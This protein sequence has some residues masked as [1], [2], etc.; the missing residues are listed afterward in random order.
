M[1]GLFNSLRRRLLFVVAKRGIKR[2]EAPIWIGGISKFNGNTYLGKNTNFNGIK[3]VGQGDFVVGDN[4]H[5]GSGLI[6]ITSNHRFRNATRIPYDQEHILKTVKIED[7]VWIGERVTIL[8][9]VHIGEGAIIQAGSV[10][11]KSVKALTIVGGNPAKEFS[12]R[13]SAEY[14]QLKSQKK[15][16]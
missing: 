7:N 1:R 15:T 13:D 14:Y 5:S 16:H 6:V 9:G 4:F 3:V 2:Y 8:P 12:V 11:I 10:V